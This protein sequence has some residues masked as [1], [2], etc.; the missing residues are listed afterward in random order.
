MSRRALTAINWAALA[1]RI[2][3]TEK[4]ALAAFKSKS[5]KYLQR[6]NANPE[7]MPKIDWEY[8]RKSVITP[9]LVDKFQKEFES[10]QIPYPADKYTAAIDAEKNDL[11]KKIESFKQE[12]DGSTVEIQKILD[13]INAMIPYAE[14]TMDDYCEA[15]PDGFMRTDIVTTWPHTE[16]TQEDLNAPL[17]RTDDH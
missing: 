16:E 13:S 2:P 11:A 5:D 7:A 14:M 9:G 10:L 8:Y 17:T 1:E 15:V 3:E 4:A 12:L 6:M